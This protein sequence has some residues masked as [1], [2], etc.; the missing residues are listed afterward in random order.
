MGMN[1]IFYLREGHYPMLNEI[2]NSVGKILFI[3]IYK[4]PFLKTSAS[5]LLI[6]ENWTLWI[7]RTALSPIKKIK[8]KSSHKSNNPKCSHS[9]VPFSTP[10]FDEM[11]YQLE[12]VW[13]S[14]CH[15][16][17]V[18]RKRLHILTPL[19]RCLLSSALPIEFSSP[20]Y[21]ERGRSEALEPLYYLYNPL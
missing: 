11:L 4:I 19:R 10:G 16:W 3:F 2:L 1:I 18:Y 12:V 8:H 7:C 5:S 9:Y 15:C 14:A 20:F 13:A 17:R 21:S 6:F